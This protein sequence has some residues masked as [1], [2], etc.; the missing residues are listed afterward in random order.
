MVR[1]PADCEGQSSTPNGPTKHSA[2]EH[3]APYG[4]ATAAGLTVSSRQLFF[5]GEDVATSGRL[6]AITNYRLGGVY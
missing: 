4:A 1:L 2:E 3:T 5:T 6:S